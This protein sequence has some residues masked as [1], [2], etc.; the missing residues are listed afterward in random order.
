M[1]IP[2]PDLGLQR[3]AVCRTPEPSDFGQQHDW[4]S[5]TLL[6]ETNMEFVPGSTCECPTLRSCLCT[7]CICPCSLN[8]DGKHFRNLKSL[9]NNMLLN[10]KLYELVMKCCCLLLC[11]YLVFSLLVIASDL[12]GQMDYLEQFGS[13]NVRLHFVLCFFIVCC[14]M[15]SVLNSSSP[16][17]QFKESVLRKQSLYLKFDPLM[18]ESPKKAGAPTVSINPPRPAALA[19]RYG[20]PPFPFCCSHYL[21]I[22]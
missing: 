19:S 14:C 7:V 11:T 17:S 12:D 8:V 20:P 22:S 16:A 15:D 2:A 21:S 13:A 3:E 10:N 6:V 1:S 18:R 5:Q 9:L 4:T